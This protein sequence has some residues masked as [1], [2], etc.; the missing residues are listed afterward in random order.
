MLLAKPLALVVLKLA[1]RRF[2]AAAVA[3]AAAGVVSAAEDS[4]DG[5][6]GE[7]PPV[8]TKGEPC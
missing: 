7:L 2:Q 4:V 6:S 8:G 1:L 5:V 3:A